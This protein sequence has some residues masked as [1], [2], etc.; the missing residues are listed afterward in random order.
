MSKLP[1]WIYDNL[2]CNVLSYVEDHP[3]IWTARLCRLISGLP[4]TEESIIHC[5]LCAEY[6]NPRKR[7]RAAQCPPT[8]PGWPAAIGGAYQLHPPC[9]PIGLRRLQGMLYK[10][11]DDCLMICS[12]RSRIPDSRNHRG[13][14]IATRWYPL[15]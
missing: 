4:E 1:Q 10:L 11:R 8:L 15:H 2:T 9:G 5:G 3:G 6:A 14:D 12:E 13:W 7:R